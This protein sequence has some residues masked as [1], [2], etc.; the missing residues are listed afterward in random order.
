MCAIGITFSSLFHIF[1]KEPELKP[2]K[3]K[4]QVFTVERDL[5][6]NSSKGSTNNVTLLAMRSIDELELNHSNLSVEQN[7]ENKS[8]S[9]LVET[10][11]DNFKRIKDWKDW[12]K[13]FS[14]WKIAMMYTMAKMFVDLSQVYIPLYLQETL[15]MPKVSLIFLDSLC[16]F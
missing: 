9:K 11:N 16:S 12:L 3:M 2:H 5:F 10:L 6:I 7:I 8:T 13:S 14:F 1:V 4:S 15:R